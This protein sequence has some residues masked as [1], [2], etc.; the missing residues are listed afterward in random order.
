MAQMSYNDDLCFLLLKLTAVSINYASVH[1]KGHNM[2]VLEDIIL[3]TMYNW[4][5]LSYNMN[6]YFII[7]L[8]KDVEE[9]YSQ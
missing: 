9:I 3:Y 5:Y 4:F 2:C 1:L 8:C 7:I 6:S